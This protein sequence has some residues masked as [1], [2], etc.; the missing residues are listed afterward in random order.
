MVVQNSEEMEGVEAVGVGKEE[1]ARK[2]LDGSELGWIIQNYRADIPELLHAAA[3]QI[4]D[5]RNKER[6]TLVDSKKYWLVFLNER[7]NMVY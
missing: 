2:L 1:L 7:K 4:K 3:K 6:E 5:P